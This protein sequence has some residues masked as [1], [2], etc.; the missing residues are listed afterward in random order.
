MKHEGGLRSWAALLACVLR[1]FLKCVHWRRAFCRRLG[2]GCVIFKPAVSRHNNIRMALARLQGLRAEEGWELLEFAF[3]LPALVAVLTLVA[4]C[5][6]AFYNFQQLGNATA[7]AVQYIAN[8]EGLL[9]D[10]CA[11]AVT[12]VTG[13]WQLKNWTAS[14]FSYRIAITPA[15]S[16][17]TDYYPSATTMSTGSSFTCTSYAA[18]LTTGVSTSNQPTVV[19]L[20]VSYSYNYFGVFH[21]KTGGGS[22]TSTTGTLTAVQGAVPQ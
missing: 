21:A 17:T 8:D 9:T 3:V 22:V 16:S 11:T 14:N 5:A 19:V 2:R 1:R 4:S 6:L 7:N 12:Q 18:D 13:S 10:P 15:G 20:T